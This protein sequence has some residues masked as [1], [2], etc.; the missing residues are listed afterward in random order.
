MK[1]ALRMALVVFVFYILQ[2]SV[3]TSFRISSIQPDMLAVM[4]SCITAFT[5]T[6]GAFCAG[7]VS[8]ILLDTF[9]GHVMGLYIVLYPLMGFSAAKM[10]VGFEG[11]AEKILKKHLKHWQRYLIHFVICL[12]IVALREVI[13][14]TYMF[15]NGVDIT[16]GHVLRVLTCMIYSAVMTVPADWLIHTMLYGRKKRVQSS[17]ME[18]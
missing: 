16:Y 2:T 9:V 10:R 17:D 8:G 14:V 3:F 15:L 11:I 7:C 5:G 18:G 12:I 4:L 13:F 6:Y 1:R